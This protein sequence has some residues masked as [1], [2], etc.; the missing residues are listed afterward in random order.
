MQIRFLIIHCSATRLSQHVSMADIDRWHRQ[1]GYRCIGYHYFITRDGTVHR[2][3][4]EHEVGA[5]CLGYNALSLGICYEGGLDRQG[6]PADTRTEAQRRALLQLLK[7]LKARY[8][9][10]R[11]LGHRDTGARKACPCFDAQSEYELLSSQK[12]TAA[13]A[14]TLSEST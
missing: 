6:A 7:V 10:A 9:S 3:R 12:A 2:G 4:Q 13:A 5:H 1:Q 14:A 11:I 8:P